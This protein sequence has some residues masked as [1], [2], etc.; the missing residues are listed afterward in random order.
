MSESRELQ[1]AA[2]AEYSRPSAQQTTNQATYYVIT[3]TSSA[4]CAIRVSA[5]HC[6]VQ[7]C[8]ST[9]ALLNDSVLVNPLTPTAATWVQL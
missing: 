7:Q 3:R 9:T 4:F 8:R 5:L 6:E 2:V 1:S